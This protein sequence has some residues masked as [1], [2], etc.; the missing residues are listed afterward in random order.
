LE[1]PFR[2]LRNGMNE[3]GLSSSGIYYRNPQTATGEGVLPLLFRI[4]KAAAQKK[5]TPLVL[6]MDCCNMLGV[7]QV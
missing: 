4:Y 1:I 6:A 2:Y 3:N 7:G 5:S